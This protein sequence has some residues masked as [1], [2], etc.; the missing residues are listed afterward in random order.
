[1]PIYLYRNYIFLKSVMLLQTTLS[2]FL[3]E[4]VFWSI[5]TTNMVMSF[6]EYLKNKLYEKSQRVFIDNFILF[7]QLVVHIDK[8]LKHVFFFFFF[9]FCFFCF[10]FC[11]CFVIA[12]VYHRLTA[13]V[14]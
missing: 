5:G 7:I 4:S 12:P 13:L 11:F 2:F 6:R 1:M 14:L 9:F 10:F 8:V 3:Y